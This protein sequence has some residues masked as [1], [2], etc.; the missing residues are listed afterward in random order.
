MAA[1]TVTAA[2]VQRAIAQLG[3]PGSSMELGRFG[4]TVTAGQALYRDSTDA[5]DLKLAIATSAAAAAVYGISL[6]GG[7]D[8]QPA[9]ILRAGL[10]APGATVVVGMVYCV[11]AAAAGS[12]V[13]YSDLVSTNYVSFIGVGITAALIYVNFTVSGIAKP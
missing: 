1:L 8:G 3:L 4:A 10:Y 11:S 6:N 2:D 7:A 13:P 5:Y 9:E 12:I